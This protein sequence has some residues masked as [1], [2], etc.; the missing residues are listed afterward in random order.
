MV[1]YRLLYLQPDPEVGERVCVG[2]VFQDDILFDPTFN[3]VRCLTREWS[4]DLLRLYLDEIKTQVHRLNVDFELTI[5]KFAPLFSASASR[6]MEAPATAESKLAL[7]KSYVA[8]RSPSDAVARR[9]AEF[10]AN[11]SKF[12]LSADHIPLTEV[13]TNATGKE[14][15]GKTR[16]PVSEVALAI[17]GPEQTV[18]LDGVDLNI[19][20]AKF[21]LRQAGRINHT[22]W[23][24]R[25]HAEK[26]HK[27][28]K[29]VALVFNGKSHLRAEL[30]EAHDY[31]LDQ[32]KKEAD[33]V[34]DA[35]LDGAQEEVQKY[36]VQNLVFAS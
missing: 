8:S 2:V 17:R 4:S 3:K 9:R 1:N 21:A 30:K 11:L 18:L 34:I 20:S 6:Q 26:Q 32:F 29:R 10:V 7:Y 31:A 23:Q 24:Y 28:I 5:R 27:K 19:D 25:L 15:L 13:I 36:L 22:F 16:V 35:C 12:A 33:F 14:V